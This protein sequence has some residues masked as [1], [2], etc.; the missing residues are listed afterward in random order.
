MINAKFLG[1]RIRHPYR[2]TTVVKSF[3]S[4]THDM[5]FKSTLL[6]N[7][8]CHNKTLNYKTWRLKFTNTN[9]EITLEDLIF[10]DK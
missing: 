9:K 3:N 8:P 6:I 10:G 1:S 4:K 5:P 2:G 7:P